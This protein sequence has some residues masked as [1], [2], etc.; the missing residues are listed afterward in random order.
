MQTYTHL[1]M[2]AAAYRGLKDIKTA[3]PSKAFLWGAVLPDLPLV[4]LTIGYFIFRRYDP[5]LSQEFIFGPTYDALY[6]T[7]PWWIVGHNLLHAPPM[8]GLYAL[9]GYL[10]Q[11]RGYGWGRPLLWFA[12]GCGLHSFV[13]IL[14]HVNDGPLLFFP[15]EWQTR[16]ESPVSYWDPTYGGRV[17]TLFEHGLNLVLLGYLGLSWWTK[18]EKRETENVKRE[19]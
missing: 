15:F 12:A 14:T 8:V 18:N 11:R 17:F 16:F 19:T 13:D 10:G 9:V 7:N 1:I 4:L 6:F 3:V 2:T 5:L